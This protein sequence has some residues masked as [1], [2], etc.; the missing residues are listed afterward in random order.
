MDMEQE[1]N[2]GITDE[3]SSIEERVSSDF[4]SN[5][6]L[7]FDDPYSKS[8]KII[9]DKP[10]DDLKK[11][12]T[13]KDKT[14]KA[15]QTH[16]DSAEVTQPF[17]ENKNE[18]CSKTPSSAGSSP[19]FSDEDNVFDNIDIT[20]QSKIF[21]KDEKGSTTQSI[22]SK[23]PSFEDDADD[24]DDD[25]YE[26]NG[27]ENKKDSTHIGM[28]RTV[29]ST[30]VYYTE[31][32]FKGLE[33]QQP[34]KMPTIDNNSVYKFPIDINEVKLNDGRNWGIFTTTTGLRSY[35]CEK[36]CKGGKSS[37]RKW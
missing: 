10:L 26:D 31:A 5:M 24:D 36:S 34:E 13:N 25:L 33:I 19:L 11:R 23:S 17:G 1:G 12:N 7:S 15:N 18:K 3:F 2:S 37:I 28:G 30:K 20:N 6:N 9:Q 16:D 4:P 35:L 8:K 14:T 29:R 22:K 27:K 21:D 32:Y